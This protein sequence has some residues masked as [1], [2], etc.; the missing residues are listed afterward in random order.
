MNQDN[1]LPPQLLVLRTTLLELLAAY[2]PAFRQDRVYR[3]AVAL[4]LAEIFAFARHTATQL[5][6]A[7]GLAQADWSGWY[8][9]WS[10]PRFVPERAAAIL[11]RQTLRHVPTDAPA[12]VVGVDQV[13][14]RRHSLKLPGTG[15]A[16]AA[17]TAVFR[18]GL[19]R[20]QRF[21]HGAWLT[22][23]WNGYSRAVP[24]RLLPAFPPKAVPAHTPPRKEWEAARDFIA[25]VRA[26]LDVAGRMAQ[27]LLVLGDGAYDTVEL[28]RALPERA[29][30]LARSATNRVLRALPE[31]NPRGRPRQYG[32]QL[33][34]PREWLHVSRG[35]Q[36]G[37]VPVRGHQRTLT[38]RVVGP[39]LRER[40]PDR[41]LFL[42]VVK[43]QTWAKRRKGKPP[44]R[45]QRQ[46][47]FY[48]VNAVWRDGRWQLPLPALE[49]L[50][51]AWQRWELE[52]AHREL[53]S[54]LGLGEKQCWHPRSAEVSVAWTGWVY[55]LIVLAGYAAWGLH[56][57]PA[58][59]ARWWR[60]APRWSLTTLWRSLR[61]SFWGT[62]EFR[63]LWSRAG[64]D[65][66][67][68]EGWLA[69]QLN[70][71]LGAARI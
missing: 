64:D 54:G 26:Q 43:G 16:K 15:W 31:P 46:P 37:Q 55:G 65:W 6:L 53:K 51:W 71:V 47:A 30:L 50:A 22:P 56:G 3:R 69:G 20:A 40:V 41:P 24:L 29:I 59:P 66:P 27:F 44:T 7:L 36:H 28:W 63:A 2:R 48:L 52:V 35:W 12:Y 10:V 68:M 1:T 38:Y 23:R 17:G 5:L 33:P 13:H 67:K 11:F 4:V 34:T 25:W 14:L 57:G 39:C 21:V 45:K 60:G 9:L 8:R 70:A 61:Q 58:T 42:L 62:A 32:A 49:L 19:A 18:P